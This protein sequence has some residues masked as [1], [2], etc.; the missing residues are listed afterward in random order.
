MGQLGETEDSFGNLCACDGSCVC[1]QIS[2]GLVGGTECCLQEVFPQTIFF[3]NAFT[4]SLLESPH[5]PLFSQ[6]YLLRGFHVTAGKG[7]PHQNASVLE[8]IF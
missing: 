2:C 4:Q 8:S 6:M 7:F 1:T 3:F 5:F